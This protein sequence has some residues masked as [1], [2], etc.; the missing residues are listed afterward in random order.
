MFWPISYQIKATKWF[1]RVL[2]DRAGGLQTNALG[3]VQ[4]DRMADTHNRLLATDPEYRDWFEKHDTLVFVAQMFFP[5]SFDSMG[6]SLNPALRGIFFD[7]DPLK[8]LEIGPIYTYNKVIRPIHE[9]L[10]VDVYPAI[11][12]FMAANGIGESEPAPGG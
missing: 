9:E 8:A 1:A 4:F 10:E 7:R 2:F 6:V 3:A 12:D 11:R 5:V